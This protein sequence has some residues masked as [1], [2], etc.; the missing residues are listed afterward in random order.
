MNKI[1]ISLL[2]YLIMNPIFCQER[3]IMVGVGNYEAFNCGLRHHFKKFNFEYGLGT[4]F[5]IHQQGNYNVILLGL[6]KKICNKS[7][8]KSHQLLVN[9]KNFVWRIKNRSN[10]FT[11][12]A[13][14]IG[15]SDE[16]KLKE[17]LSL[18][19][20]A[21]IIWNTVIKYER[22]TFQDV[23]YPK[24]WNANFGLSLYYRFK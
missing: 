18:S 16:I 11:A 19:I 3:E 17:K 15:L 10:L 13:P 24:E 4:D 14:S 2:F 5:N 6:G 22:R 7:N 23:G 20:Y 1:I 12:Y 8:F 21:G 9:C